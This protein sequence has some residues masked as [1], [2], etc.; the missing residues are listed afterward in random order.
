[1]SKL[2]AIVGAQ[3][4]DEGKGKIVD[5]FGENADLFV[6]YAGGANAGHTLYVA[7]EKIVLHN[8]PSGIVRRD[9]KNVVGP[10]VACD[11]EVVQHELALAARFRSSV[12]FDPRAP[13]VLPIHKAIDR[14]RERALGAAAVGTTNRGIGP[15]YEDFAA[16]RGIT[17][18]DV[19]DGR[20]GDKLR[21]GGYYAERVAVCAH[22]GETP[23]TLDETVA[24]AEPFAYLLQPHLDDVAMLVTCYARDPKSTIV[25]EGAQGMMLDVIA[26]NR[27]YCTSSLTGIAAIQASFGLTP[28]RV[29]GVTKAYATRVGGGP[30]PSEL[31]GPV[32]DELRQ[33]GLEY[34]ATTGRPRRVGWLDLPALAFA[35]RMGSVTELVINKLDVLSGYP[36]F[37][38]A[39]GY[40][41]NGKRVSPNDTLTTP[42]LNG[43]EAKYHVFCGWHEEISTC[44]VREQLPEA[45][46]AYLAYIQ[47]VLG[48]PVTGI[49]VGPNRDDIIWDG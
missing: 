40:L 12:D 20:V 37:Q 26:G 43:A 8:L 17:L 19:A 6:R 35:C 4:G 48:L 22:L 23:M 10:Y 46:R 41:L 2:I 30:F 42:L 21:A 9:A 34:G 49:G 15:C 36:E 45:A 32:G 16:R 29:I 28:D 18:S 44:R 47:H 25:F 11:L 3:W 1:M 5:V 38:L 7:G 14:G 33:R 31:E 27:P 39:T 24:W 13:V